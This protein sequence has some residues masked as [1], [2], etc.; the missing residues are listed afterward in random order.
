VMFERSEVGRV[1][2]DRLRRFT[3]DHVAAVRTTSSL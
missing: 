3:R 2:H 1:T